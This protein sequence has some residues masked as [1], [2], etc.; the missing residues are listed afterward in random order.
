MSVPTAKTVAP[1]EVVR[2]LLGSE[3]VRRAFRFFEESA[4]E[5]DAEH[6]AICEVPAPPFGESERAEVLREKLLACG[7]AGA[8]IDAEGNCVALRRGRSERPLL[9]LSAHLDTVFP[10]G[11]DCTVSRDASG[12]MR[13]PGV[14]DDGCGLAALVAVARALNEFEIETEG[15]ILFVATV[16]EEGEGDL[17]GVRHLLTAG[18]WAGR[19][20]AFISIDGPGLERITHAALASRRYRVTYRGAGGHS[21]GDFG[22]PNPV[23][24]LGRAVARL[25]AYPAPRRPRTTF[26]VGRIEGGSGVNVIPREAHM[27]VD[28]RSESGVELGRLDA[29]FRRAAREAAEDETAARRPGA[30]PLELD[31]KLIG[32]RPGGVTPPEH[33]LVR[34]AAEAT[35]VVG[36]KPFLDCSSTD[37]NIPISRGMPAV[38]IGAGGTSGSTHTLEEWYDPAGRDLG[39]K[40]ALLFALGAVGVYAGG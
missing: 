16:G 30:P 2:G 25:A 6:A 15:S 31:I 29:F 18:E 19:V 26:N 34:L 12:R 3:R 21:W 1:E 11:T 32:D 27:D 5:F 22:V 40:R 4:G 33:A 28:L 23:H 17:R 9:A 14:A 24:A 13:A 20:D 38:T 7:L 37:S 39:L 35:R 10:S 36:S 8:S